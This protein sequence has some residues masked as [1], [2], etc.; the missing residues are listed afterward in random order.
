[1]LD[2]LL[3]VRPVP[4]TCFVSICKRYVRAVPPAN[5]PTS[6]ESTSIKEEKTVIDSSGKTFAF[7]H[8]Y[9]IIIIH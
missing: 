3:L 2:R 1:M 5:P 4:L 9:V 6:T 7:K 8:G